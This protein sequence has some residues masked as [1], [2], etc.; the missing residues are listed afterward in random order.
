MAV[1]AELSLGMVTTETPP[2]PH[3]LESR[4]YEFVCSSHR[5]QR[6]RRGQWGSPA[7]VRGH[8]LR[9]PLGSGLTRTVHPRG[10][11]KPH[12]CRRTGAHTQGSGYSSAPV[13]AECGGPASP[14]AAWGGR[15][16]C[17]VRREKTL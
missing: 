17:L 14:G 16:L 6:P 5:P 4:F 9:R 13:G 11:R 7:S 2:V 1:V 3:I 15:F 12:V 10:G 8:F